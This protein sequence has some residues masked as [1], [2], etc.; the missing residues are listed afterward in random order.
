MGEKLLRP[1]TGGL[2]EKVAIITGASRGVGK[3]LALA[4][5]REG[6]VLSLWSR[7]EKD[8]DS[9]VREIEADNSRG[10]PPGRPYQKAGGSKILAIPLDITREKDVEKGIEEVL[11]RFKKVDILVNNA[12]HA[13]FKTV[14]DTGVED[15]D[16]TMAV[17]LRGSF[18][19]TKA[20]LPVMLKR[21]QGDIVFV[22]S[23]AGLE[24]FPEW[25]GYCASKFGLIGFS[26]SLAKEVRS[27]GVRVITVCPGAVDTP[28]W[29]NHPDPPERKE[30]LK[31]EEVAEAVLNLLTFSRKAVADVTV[32]TPGKGIL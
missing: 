8:L 7:S 17:N 27:N 23:V 24:G 22:S 11:K 20:V 12:G 1:A 32:I 18:L 14:L 2:A 21:R 29:D 10:D 6:A 26:K 5:A 31:A 25:S 3:A 19:A 30:M 16:R 15:W 28:L 9:V 4:F 13:Y